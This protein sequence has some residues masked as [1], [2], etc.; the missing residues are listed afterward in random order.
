MTTQEALTALLRDGWS[1]TVS[2][3]ACGFVAWARRG[4]IDHSEV[5]AYAESSRE[6]VPKL[7]E[8]CGA[9]AGK[10]LRSVG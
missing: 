3:D 5:K 7:A 9:G 1:I 10:E 4:I 6:I 2:R 8:F